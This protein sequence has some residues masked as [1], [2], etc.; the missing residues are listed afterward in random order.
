MPGARSTV[1]GATA[2]AIRA[3]DASN[4]GTRPSRTRQFLMG[5]QIRGKQNG[6]RDCSWRGRDDGALYV[7]YCAMLK[8]AGM[9]IT[10]IATSRDWLV[11]PRLAVRP[12][13]P[14][15]CEKRD[16]RGTRWAINQRGVLNVR[17]NASA[18]EIRP[19]K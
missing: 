1:A 3:P 9:A 19:R 5:S 13:C 6:I 2:G 7:N 11:N 4:P 16:V 17:S 12:P 10:F 18:I 8:R 14:C 15:A